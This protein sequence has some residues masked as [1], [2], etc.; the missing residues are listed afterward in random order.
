[1]PDSVRLDK[2]LWAV[3]LYKTRSLAAKEC[4]AGKI[5]RGTTTL[6]PSSAVQ[7]ADHLEIP[8]H[9]GTHKRQLEVVQL[10]DKRVSGPLAREA[11]LDR[12]PAETLEAA[13]QLREQQRQDRLQRREGDQGRMT[14]K[15]RRRWRSTFFDNQDDRQG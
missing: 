9:D 11:F 15:N 14:K 13:R 1:M 8:A 7:I 5:K 4:S 2:W 3:R 10:L 6:K 12:T